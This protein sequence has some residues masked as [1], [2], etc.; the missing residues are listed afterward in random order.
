MTDQDKELIN[1]LKRFATDLGSELVFT[2]A[3]RIEELTEERDMA[4]RLLGAA[5]QMQTETQA[6][7]AKA[8]EA[9]RGWDT[10]YKTGRN[11]PLQIAA[12]TTRATLAELEGQ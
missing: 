5:T 11:E 7:L 9:L 12:E 10:A 6:K 4:R 1:R 3:D 8:I 2:A